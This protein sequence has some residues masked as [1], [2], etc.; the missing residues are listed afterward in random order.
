M[1]LVVITILKIMSSFYLVSIWV[2]VFLFL[3]RLSYLIYYLVLILFFA[4]YKFI[5]TNFLLLI[6]DA[7]DYCSKA[8]QQ[9][10]QCWRFLGHSPKVLTQEID[11]SPRIQ[12][13]ISGKEKSISRSK[14]TIEKLQPS[15][16]LPGSEP[17]LLNRG[18]NP[19]PRLPVDNSLPPAI[20]NNVDKEAHVWFSIDIEEHII[21]FI[22]S[23]LSSQKLRLLDTDLMSIERY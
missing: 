16:I 14:I 11:C 17:R 6:V 8:Y 22:D 20:R 3:F 18:E 10:C 15:G 21:H 4:F 2:I 5:I 23:V 9:E 1:S 19:Q 7:E 12:G 13:K